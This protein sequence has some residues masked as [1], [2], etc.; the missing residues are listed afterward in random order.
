MLGCGVFD[1]VE[2]DDELQFGLLV[3]CWA[4]AMAWITLAIVWMSKPLIANIK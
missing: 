4:L 2:S 1:L 3:C